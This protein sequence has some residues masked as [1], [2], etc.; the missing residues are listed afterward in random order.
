MLGKKTLITVLSLL[1]ML[2]MLIS[3]GYVLAEETPP[4]FKDQFSRRGLAVPGLE[5]LWKPQQAPGYP[6]PRGEDKHPEGFMQQDEVASV[7]PTATGGPDDFGY[8][9][10]DGEPFDWIDAAELGENIDLYGGDVYT[11]SPVP[12]GFAFPYYGNIY[13]E[14][15][16][17]TK[18]LV[19]FSYGGYW[20]DIYPIPSVGMPDDFIAPLWS[21]LG[22]YKG[23]NRP[24]AGIFV[25]SAG[26]EPNRYFVIEWHR[27]DGYSGESDIGYEV[28]DL[29]FQLI[30]HENGDIVMQYG[31][32][33][34]GFLWRSVGIEDEYGM[35]GSQ[36][37]YNS[38]GLANELAVRF[39]YPPPSARVSLG[40]ISQSGFAGA[41]Q[42]ADYALTLRNIGD[43]G[44]DSYTLVANSTW[45]LAFFEEDGV[46]PI[47]AVIDLEQGASLTFIARVT[48]PAGAAV[49]EANEAMVTATSGLDATKSKSVT[50]TAAFPAPF[51]QVLF[52]SVDDLLISYLVTPESQERVTPF[53]EATNW[54]DMGILELPNSNLLFTWNQVAC[55]E[56][57]GG[58][59]LN[60]GYAIK[61]AISDRWGD[62]VL[63]PTVL[64]ETSAVEFDYFGDYQP[65]LAVAPNGNIGVLWYRIQEIYDDEAGTSKYNYNIHFAILDP[66]GEVLHVPENITGD[67]GYYGWDEIGYTGY[68]NPRLAA[69]EDGR[70]LLAWQKDER[71][72]TGFLRDIF[73]SIRSNTGEVEVAI[74]NLTGSTVDVYV[75][76]LTLTDLEGEC[77]FIAWYQDREIC[78]ESG[79]W[80]EWAT[81]YTVLD[82]SGD[83]IKAQDY[84]NYTS[85]GN[86]DSIQLS[87]GTI[88]LAGR[89]WETIG[90]ILFDGNSYEPLGE[91]HWLPNLEAWN[92]YDV[93]VTKD[94]AGHAILTWVSYGPSGSRLAYALIASDGEL[95]TAPILFYPP[96]GTDYVWTSRNGQG[97]TTYR[98]NFPPFF[99]SEPVTQGLEGELYIYTI[100]TDDHDLP[101][102]TLIISAP[103]K[104][105]WLM[106]SDN[107]DGTA[108]LSGTPGEVEVGEHAVELQVADSHGLTATQAFTITVDYIN[109]PPVF[110][111]EPVITAVEEVPYTYEITADDPDLVYG[112]TLTISVPTK[113]DWLTFSDN[114][115]GTAIL[116]GTPGKVDVGEHAVV[117]QVEDSHGL[118]ATQAFIITV[119][120]KEVEGFQLFLPMI[121]R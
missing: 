10:D 89:S 23:G 75:G 74:T 63:L 9:W 22:M 79:C 5:E 84:L 8:T 109:D 15:F 42:S 92:N 36:Y 72:E 26:S 108:S 86:P 118:M 120:E 48:A 39:T 69:T 58:T 34:D 4:Q 82:S 80:W 13:E 85:F 61:Y 14:L 93:S 99:T 76:N 102:D 77:V 88:I 114:G 17:T 27:A 66:E 103:T 11:T 37:L 91:Q 70:F 12:I 65:Y 43:L 1:V 68:W 45:P 53:D 60:W 73:Y 113:P 6:D 62:A 18:G 115:D 20:Y 81:V 121:L 24:E 21:D 47:D 94:M 57:D 29:T 67:E 31:W 83:E 50:I 44:T 7:A 78:D 25:H 33:D 28:M 90:Y 46:T 119:D 112:D 56:W 107:G 71:T 104:P 117:L 49:G 30:L 3:P 41:G 116:S 106:F 51:A 96:A 101:N 87:D 55:I 38:P 64:S 100:T 52:D 111:S 59:C 110:T 97:N 32:I 2:G 19:S 35:D 98:S 16:I 105:G 54:D 40:P 95:V